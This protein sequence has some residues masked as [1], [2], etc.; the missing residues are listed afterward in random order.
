M[1]G[2]F[3]KSLK[4]SHPLGCWGAIPIEN[5]GD[6]ERELWPAGFKV[7]HSYLFILR[8]WSR[9]VE[10]M[11]RILAD[12]FSVS[13]PKG[14]G[15]NLSRHLLA[16]N[17]RMPCARAPEMYSPGYLLGSATCH[18][19]IWALSRWIAD[20]V[21][22]LSV[23]Q[24]VAIVLQVSRWQSFSCGCPFSALV[25]PSSSLP[26][27][28]VKKEK[29]AENSLF[30]FFR[31]GWFFFLLF[32]IKSVLDLIWNKSTVLWHLIGE[33]QFLSHVGRK[34]WCPSIT[35]MVCKSHV[36]TQQNWVLLAEVCIA[37]KLL[38][39][40]APVLVWWP[41]LRLVGL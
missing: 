38:F 6:N 34:V 18:F 37:V 14:T 30:F 24:R 39:N 23:C 33:E 26:L 1:S 28:Y 7:H 32:Y 12:K 16:F 4:P 10:W 20:D 27:I 36:S 22:P 29:R 2:F 19:F 41:V 8:F 13:I 5:G 11:T 21:S 15:R 35:H 31:K 9:A 17:G 3:F 25:S 40:L